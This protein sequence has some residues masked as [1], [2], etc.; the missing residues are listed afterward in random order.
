[1]KEIEKPA[2]RILDESPGEQDGVHYGKYQIQPLIRGFGATLGN[3]LRR[4]LLSSIPG[5]AAVYLKIDG[6]LHE[7]TSI[8]GV[9]EDVTEIVL[10]VK[11]LPIACNSDEPVAVKLNVKGPGEITA[12]DVQADDRV[13]I[14]DPSYHIATITG[15]TLVKME[16]GVR[17]GR[18]YVPA[19]WHEMD[20]AVPKDRGVIL[21]DSDFSPIRRVS[22][23]VEPARVGQRTDYDSL[24]IEIETDSTISPADSLSEAAKI[25]L[26]EFSF[27][28]DFKEKI[29]KEEEQKEE[30]EKKKSQ[31]MKKSIDELDL[32]VRSYNCLK[33]A[34]IESVEDLLNCS[35]S[36]LKGLRNFGEKSLKEIVAKLK[37]MGLSLKPEEPE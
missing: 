24:L 16:I 11:G 2:I 4:V 8:K 19:E 18:G 5:S 37:V 28:V 27:V 21:L 6:V 32:S 7:F 15:D 31:D 33:N 3:S 22:F 10:N 35:E 25:L 26:R 9:V 30:Q 23:S 12:G 29:L 20:P 34:N 36:Q 13:E 17:R 14:T 1:M